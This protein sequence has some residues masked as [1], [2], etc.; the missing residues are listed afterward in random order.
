MRNSYN[1]KQF[2]EINSDLRKGS[3][4]FKKINDENSRNIIPNA[5]IQLQSKFFSTGNQFSQIFDDLMI[6]KGRHVKF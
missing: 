3:F 4:M 6:A 2:N 1:K 5:L